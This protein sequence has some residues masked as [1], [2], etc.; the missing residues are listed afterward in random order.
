[1]GDR[2][3]KAVMSCACVSFGDTEVWTVRV[4]KGSS[5]RR[6]HSPERKKG[7]RHEEWLRR[8][9]PE[10]AMR[11]ALESAKS[12]ANP[13]SWRGP[14][15]DDQAKASC[16]V[17]P[18]SGDTSGPDRWLMDTGS[19]YDLVAKSDVP[20]VLLGNAY[21][22][23]E[24]LE[25]HTANGATLADTVVDLQVGP[26]L[27]V[28]SPLLLES[29]PAVL[30]IG[31][32]CMRDGYGFYWSPFSDPYVITPQGYKVQ[33]DV[34]GDVPYLRETSLA[35]S[36]PAASSSDPMP[37]GAEDCWE[38]RA[39]G[40]IVRVHKVPRTALFNPRGFADI[41]VALGEMDD[42]RETVVVP[43]N[44]DPV[45]T[46]LDSWKDPERE[47]FN[48]GKQWVGHTV[49]R[50]KSAVALFGGE[51]DGDIVDAHM[52]LC[53]LMTHH[54]KLPGRSSCQRAKMQRKPH[55]KA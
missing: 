12:M 20:H 16:R 41:P 31:R 26:L 28:V 7:Y 44:G 8:I 45:V 19:G 10:D 23:E 43:T 38:T 13:E 55:R 39:D 40:T 54:P 4:P 49:F 34:V 36:C 11:N 48:M 51:E 46:E 35:V 53:H 47:C 33:L 15:A 24:S 2:G 29:T 3:A 32:R 6:Y 22:A 1:M 50:P 42:S 37:A 18:A 30:S 14:S 5:L 52:S 27:E 25:L 21:R 17:A 9:T